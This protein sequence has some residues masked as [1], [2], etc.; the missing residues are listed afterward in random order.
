M[1]P[2]ND[3]VVDV[4]WESFLDRADLVWIW[5]SELVVVFN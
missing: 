2:V 1:S 4:N 3:V 5:N